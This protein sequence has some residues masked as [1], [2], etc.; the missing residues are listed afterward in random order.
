M[1]AT[2]TSNCVSE[3]SPSAIASRVVSG[4]GSI[5]SGSNFT[6]QRISKGLYILTY[7]IP[8]ADLPAVTVSLYDNSALTHIAIS[9]RNIITSP[10]KVYVE[11]KDFDAGG[12]ANHDSDFQ[13]IAIG[14]R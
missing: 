4:S 7:S 11:V 3:A 13:F 14:S 10:E 12:N 2:A 1:N 5:I 9:T 8:F 6:V